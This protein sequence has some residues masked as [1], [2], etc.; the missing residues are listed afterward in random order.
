MSF[1]VE[2]WIVPTDEKE[3][4]L[5]WFFWKFHIPGLR[6]NCKLC[7]H[8]WLKYGLIFLW[9]WIKICLAKFQFDLQQNFRSTLRLVYDSSTITLLSFETPA[10]LLTHIAILK[11]IKK[12]SINRSF[13]A[14]LSFKW[15]K[16][17][18]FWPLFL[19]YP[20]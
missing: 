3:P 1:S 6:C 11:I 19:N 20:E 17:K 14:Y 15:P 9:F 18:K 13:S 2:H 5:V 12:I 4:W 7:F 10:Q 16:Q 8:N